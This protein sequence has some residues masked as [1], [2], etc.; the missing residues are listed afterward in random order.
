ML[1]FRKPAFTFAEIMLTLLIVGIVAG[2]VLPTLLKDMQSKSRMALMK[3]TVL[4]IDEMVQKDIAQKRTQDITKLEIY[5][6]KTQNFLRQFDIAEN[7]VPFANANS[8]KNY[9]GG[10]TQVIVPGNSVLLKSGVGIGVVERLYDK[11]SSAIVIDLTGE[12]QPNTVGIDY[13]IAEMTWD[14]D[15]DNGWHLGDIHGYINGGVELGEEETETTAGLKTLCRGGNASA[16]YRYAEL[17][18]FEHD[19]IEK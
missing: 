5:G 1:K 12:N 15:L 17:L 9:N 11:E 13:F 3:S 14:D 18:N 16:C 10:S 19:Y 2:L 8:Y 7:G 6:N 4:S